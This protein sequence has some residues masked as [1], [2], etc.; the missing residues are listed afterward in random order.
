MKSFLFFLNRPL[1]LFLHLIGVPLPLHTVR[2]EMRYISIFFK[3]FVNWKKH[4]PSLQYIN[5]KLSDVIYTLTIHEGDARKRIVAALPNLKKLNPNTFP[6]DPKWGQDPTTHK[7]GSSLLLTHVR[8][9]CYML[10]HVTS[11]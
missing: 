5:S 6:S 2:W 10:Q 3:E 1:N 9:K 4:M 7:M 11:T 8:I